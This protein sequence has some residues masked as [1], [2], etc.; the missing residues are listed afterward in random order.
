MKNRNPYRRLAAVWAALLVLLALTCASA[1]VEMGVW[2]TVTNFG[3][4]A[5]K[6]LLVA[7]FFMHL[8]SGRAVHR[9]VALSAGFILALLM[10]LTFTDYSTRAQHQAAWQSPR[11]AISSVK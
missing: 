10:G 4:A 6:A 5:V 9:I 2:N 11:G 8:F 1:F 3:I 7:I